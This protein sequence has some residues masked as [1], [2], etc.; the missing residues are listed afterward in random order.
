MLRY[1]LSLGSNLGDRRAHLDW[2]LEQLAKVGR[3]G[4]VSSVHE[5]KAWGNPDQPDFL[6]AAAEFRTDLPPE[7][8]LDMIKEIE[9]ASGRDLAAPRW[10][11]RPLDIDILLCGDAT[12]S[13]PRLTIPHA[14]MLNREFVLAP[15]AE[16]APDV[17]VPGAAKT[18]GE[19]WAEWRSAHPELSAARPA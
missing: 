18:C 10:S 14:E 15:L 17:T 13:T 4:R 3:V 16:I 5:T 19:I 6:N 8:L 7:T 2:G 12:R 11:P 1:F 9:K